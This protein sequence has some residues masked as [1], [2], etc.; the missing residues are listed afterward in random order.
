V[1]EG[2]VASGDQFVASGD[3]RQEIVR[4]LPDLLC[5]E[6]EGAAVAQVCFEN[7]KP[8]TVVRTISDTADSMSPLDFPAF[9]ETMAGFYSRR[10]IQV[11]L[12]DQPGEA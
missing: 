4:L 7:G 5:V 12:S 2:L 6:M 9:L 10:I 3:Q 11:L 8:V 1:V